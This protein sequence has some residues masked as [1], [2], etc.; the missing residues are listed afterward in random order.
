MTF[1]AGAQF[2]PSYA[3]GITGVGGFINEKGAGELESLFI[4]RFL[5]VPE[6]FGTT[7]WASASGTTGALRAPG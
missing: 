6:F 4:R 2:G 7:A 1:N 3:S 5:E